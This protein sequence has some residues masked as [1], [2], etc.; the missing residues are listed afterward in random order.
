MAH[1][2]GTQKKQKNAFVA[3]LI[4]IVIVVA[5]IA[6]VLYGGLTAK[7]AL[8]ENQDFATALAAIFD[9]APAFIN[10]EDF[11]DIKYVGVQ[12]SSEEELAMV[13]T[14]GADYVTLYNDYSAKVEAGE[15]VS[16]FD[17]G[18][19][20]KA[21]YFELDKENTKLDDLK[22]FTDAEIIEAY[23]VTFTDSSVFAGM[24]NLTTA[25]LNSCGLTEVAGF[26]GLD[27]EKVESINLA[28]NDVTDWSPLDYIKDKVVV[29]SYQTIMPNEDGTFDINNLQ[30]V[31]QTLTEY[32]EELA[33]AEEEAAE[34]NEA[35]DEA[36]TPAE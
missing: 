30:V 36:E 4:A 21:A 11:T 32:Y 1:L 28:G 24:T 26:A 15:D 18:N 2:N 7:S 16:S 22:F 34:E 9:K 17:W 5:A 20:V 6:Y 31:D 13:V 19:N 23:G 29:A 14:G 3:M 25:T 33:A 27:A 10:E 35:S 12:Y 8:L